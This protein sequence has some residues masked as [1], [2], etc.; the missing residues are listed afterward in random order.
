MRPETASALRAIARMLFAAMLLLS[1]T[2]GLL[3]GAP[4]TQPWMPFFGALGA[5]YFGLHVVNRRARR[6][7]SPRVWRL[8][9]QKT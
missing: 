9:Q 8:P 6:L 3:A 1:A 7:S 5:F 4:S 2:Y